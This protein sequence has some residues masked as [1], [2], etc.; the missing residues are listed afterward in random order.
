MAKIKLDTIV[1]F[2]TQFSSMI[3]ASIPLVKTLDN[4]Q[5]D[6]LDRTFADV[7]KEIKEDVESGVD[8]A[9][10]IAKHQN[11]FDTI[12]INMVRA[13]M[14]SGKLDVTLVQLSTYLTKAAQTANKIKSALSYPKFM[15]IA[16]TAI[17]TLMLVKVI[18]M[19]EKMFANGNKELPL[20]TQ[21]AITASDFLRESGLFLLVFL[22]LVWLGIK[23]FVATPIGRRVLDNIKLKIFFLGKLNHKSAVSKFIRTFGVLVGSDVP[24]L[25]AIKLSKSSCA[26]VILEERVDEIA[27]MVEKGF[28]ISEAFREVEVFPDIVVQMISSGEESGN[29]AELL[30]NSAEYYDDQ[31]DNELKSVVSLINPIMTVIMGIFIAALMAAIFM[32]I[33]QMGDTI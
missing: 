8:F 22:I 24:I 31:I 3:K 26:N 20:L 5:K 25:K 11:A 2:T 21:Y 12:Y 32:P 33:F 23:A 17:M 13:G 27:E 30:I 19:F 6:I 7:I 18:P 16:M 29:L 1:T 4:L 9:D 15:G 10:A 14:E 28:D